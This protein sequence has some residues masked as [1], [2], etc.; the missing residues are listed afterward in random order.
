M[1][2]LFLAATAH[3]H[4]HSGAAKHL[5]QVSALLR[6]PWQLGVLALVVLLHALQVGRLLLA[7][8]A[9]V[10]GVASL[11]AQAIR[12]AGFAAT[13]ADSDVES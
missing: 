5:M 7:D 10:L 12:Q 3:G 9:L 8:V 4:T 11:A 1:P 2:A 13:W 6:L